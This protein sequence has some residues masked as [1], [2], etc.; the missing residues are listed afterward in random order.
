MKFGEVGFTAVCCFMLCSELANF[1][2][3]LHFVMPNS[4]N[5][6][7][8]SVLFIGVQQDNCIYSNYSCKIHEAS[9]IIE[10][11]SFGSYDSLLMCLDV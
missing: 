10:F 9:Y 4:V 8:T 1:L 11:S 2:V 5:C 7:N 3:D 6:S